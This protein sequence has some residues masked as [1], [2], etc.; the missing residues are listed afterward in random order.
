MEKGRVLLLSAGALFALAV[1]SILSLEAQGVGE[2]Q[3]NAAARADV[4]K[5]DAMKALGALELPPVTF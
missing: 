4:V 2:A 1:V 5:I 3:A